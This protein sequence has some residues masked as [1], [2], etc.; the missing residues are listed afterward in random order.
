MRR[1]R[2]LIEVAGKDVEM[3]FLA[4]NLEWRAQSIADLYKC[5]WQIEV[6]FKVR[7]EVVYVIV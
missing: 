7:R 4:N 6:F 3:E 5:R 2:A 1:V